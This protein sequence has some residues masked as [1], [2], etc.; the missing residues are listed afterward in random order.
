MSHLTSILISHWQNW[1]GSLEWNR[2]YILATTTQSIRKAPYL[3]R[4]QGHSYYLLTNHSEE[5]MK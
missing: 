5:V 3:F 2:D 1:W 4:K